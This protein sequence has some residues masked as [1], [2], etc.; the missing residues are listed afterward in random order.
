M[1]KPETFSR[2]GRRPNSGGIWLD[3]S[4]LWRNSVH[5]ETHVRNRK[6]VY[7]R[8][9]LESAILL[10][11]EPLRPLCVYFRLWIDVRWRKAS[12]INTPAATEM[13]RLS[14]S[15]F[16]GIIA[17][18]ANWLIVALDSPV[19]SQPNKTARGPRKSAS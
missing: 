3:I 1:I 16:I 4:R 6:F 2:I 7:F 13:L 8:G 15:P 19:A 17:D 11:K 5:E 12:Y 18:S 10:A 14:Q 9:A